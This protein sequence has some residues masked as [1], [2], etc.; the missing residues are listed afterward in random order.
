MRHSLAD[1]TEAAVSGRH[2]VDFAEDSVHL[3]E[4]TGCHAT[5]LGCNRHT[6]LGAAPVVARRNG[7]H[8]EEVVHR[9]LGEGLVGAARSHRI[10]QVVVLTAARRTG[11]EEAVDHIHHTA[12]PAEDRLAGRSCIADKT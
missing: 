12:V 4:G 1:G 10:D 8:V 9:N 5:E 7:L 3:V 6:A 11:R 2:K